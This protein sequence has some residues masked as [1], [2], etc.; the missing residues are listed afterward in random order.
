MPAQ[1]LNSGVPRLVGAKL[2]QQGPQ[3]DRV[4]DHLVHVECEPQA[5]GCADQPVGGRERR[6]TCVEC[7][8]H[9]GG[10]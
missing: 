10:E 6:G 3:D 2:E 1:W 9:V 4:H 8:F 7:G 5:C